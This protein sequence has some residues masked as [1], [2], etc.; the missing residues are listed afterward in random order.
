MP[1]LFHLPV[2]FVRAAMNLC[3]FPSGGAFG[4]LYA[5]RLLVSLVRFRRFYTRLPCVCGILGSFK[6]DRFPHSVVILGLRA[7]LLARISQ[8]RCRGGPAE[9]DG[10]LPCTKMTG[11]SFR[12]RTEATLTACKAPPLSSLRT[13]EYLRRVPTPKSRSLR[14]IHSITSARRRVVLS[15]RRVSA[16]S[17]SFSVVK[18]LL[19]LP[20]PPPACS[21][22]CLRNES[23][24]TTWRL[25]CS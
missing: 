25:S 2:C 18:K 19:S 21:K 1:R 16:P 5:V 20:I 8:R 17:D 12:L 11:S 14:A 9:Q 4:R 6:L 15:S 13:S 22:L 24:K 10:S 3:G 23:L 7:R